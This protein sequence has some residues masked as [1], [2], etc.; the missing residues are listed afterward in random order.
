M[1]L[2][3]SFLSHHLLSL[4]TAGLSLGFAA[5]VLGQQRPTGSA[6]AW[7]LV[8]FLVPYLGIP[9]YLIFGGRKYS[10]RARSKSSLALPRPAPDATGRLPAGLLGDPR[11][12][13]GTAD[14]VDWLDDGM[15]AY[16]AFLQGI[17]SAK[18][19][20]RLVTFVVGD[21][22]TGRPLLEALAERAEAGVE[23]R[24]LLDDL[25][26][27]RAP[28]RLLSRITRAGGRVERFMPLLHIPFRGRSN[29]RNHRKIAIFD[30][31]RAI[32]GGMNLADEYMGPSPSSTRWRDLSILVGGEAVAT[33]DLIFRADWE[34]ACGERLRPRET[35]ASER[36]GS[37]TR[38][39]LFVVPS[40]PD[41]PTDPIYDALATA[42][43]RA[44]WRFWVAT[45]Y[46]VPDEALARAL[47]IAARRGVD[48][49]VIVPE[50][51]NHG[52]ADLA[53]GP[54]LRDLEADGVSVFRHAT[55]LHAK[56][57][58]VD[59]RLAVVGSANFDMRSLFLDYEVAFFLTGPAEIARLGTWFDETLSRASKGAPTAGPVRAKV[60]DVARLLSPLM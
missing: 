52:L 36:A 13:F 59:D 28:D 30:G 60:E 39:P 42:I 3:G 1:G 9:L 19:S 4:L 14:R 48:V 31:A 55:M 54:S 43:F 23:V 27:F 26:R 6:F 10:R 37:P 24:L 12:S 35:P 46:F 15:V 25:L 7:L 32:V 49:R 53:A 51:S 50:T 41:S 47:A 5:R 40:G 56:T 44:E 33:L 22:T 45:P 2:L 11:I 34:F 29:L 38:V 16:E 21:D 20:I 17:E 18:K 57:V 8:I 58:I